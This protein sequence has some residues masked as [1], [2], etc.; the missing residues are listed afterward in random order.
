MTSSPSATRVAGTGTPAVSRR[1]LHLA[2]DRAV[3][4]PL[5]TITAAHGYGKTEVLSS[6]ARTRRAGW[7]RA[8]PAH[9]V[10]AVLGAALAAAVRTAPEPR[11]W[12]ADLDVRAIV[13]RLTTSVDAPATVVIDEADALVAGPAL[14]VIRALASLSGSP[15]RL[16]MGSRVELGVAD[17]WLR[18]RGR[19]LEL[20]A[21][22]LRFDLEDI[23][24]V[25]GTDVA[26]R[27]PSA[28]EAVA[29]A[30]GGWPAGVEAAGR[31]LRGRSGSASTG[32][33]PSLVAGNGPVVAVA[34]STLLAEESP[35]SRR[36][37]AEVALLGASTAGRLAVVRGEPY[38][39]TAERLND[40]V[41][42]GLASPGADGPYRE[43]QR[44]GLLPVLRGAVVSVPTGAEADALAGVAAEVAGALLGARDRV[45]ALHVLTAAG[46]GE[47]IAEVLEAHAAELLAT[48][49]HDV[50]A[51][52]AAAV[53]GTART[54]TVERLHGDALQARGEWDAAL[55]RYLA[56]TGGDGPLTAEVALRI[57]RLHHLRGDLD[58]AI[59]VFAR[60][61]T[62]LDPDPVAIELWSWWATAH[63]LRGE[64]EPAGHRLAVAEDH[65]RRDGGPRGL[66]FVHTVRSLLATGDG[67]ATGYERAHRAAFAAA[68]RA[69]DRDQLARL[70]VNRGSHHLAEGR[71]TEALFEIERAI[72]LTSA[73]T[74][75][76]VRP[77]A[78]C[79]RAEILVRT[80]RLDEAEADAATARAELEALGARTASYA[81]HLLGDVA[82]ERGDLDRAVT[83]YRR[84][85]DVAGDQADHQAVLPATIG[86]VR[87]LAVSDPGRAAALASSLI[88][89]PGAEGSAGVWLAGAWA[90]LA[91]DDRGLAAERA[92]EAARIAGLRADR[93]GDAEAATVSALLAVDPVT[94]LRD[95][96]RRWHR[97]HDPLWAART[98][99]GL[100]R[101]SHDLGERSRAADLE[102]RLA[103]LGCDVRGGEIG[104][105][106]LCAGTA[107]PLRIRALGGLTIE[108]YGVPV[109]AWGAGVTRRVL[110]VLIV[111]AGRGVSR[112]E[113]ARRIWPERRFADV[114]AP[115][116]QAVRALRDALALPGMR[117]GALEGAARS[118]HL[119]I[120]RVELDLHE[121][122]RAVELGQRAER[123]GR[124]R[125]ALLWLRTAQQLHRGALLAGEP[126]DTQ[127]GEPD[128]VSTRRATVE[129]RRDAVDRALVRIGSR[130]DTASRR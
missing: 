119:R 127:A 5:V 49:Q 52:A 96:A 110:A 43:A 21:S 37:L 100:A 65:A 57:G 51:T 53:H 123:S 31:Y 95:A 89:M 34:R 98:E 12:P 26:S 27:W 50:V 74:A 38:A 63:W 90:A 35:G 64:R 121:F 59:A 85:L 83:R 125:E 17:P 130:S 113:L 10:P 18:G 71:Y 44:I 122:E 108:R 9:R 58:E 36:L 41:R 109:E 7:L 22:D 105:R 60:A 114:E 28:V 107:A 55:E 48:G 93:R 24:R 61:R 33:L 77:I 79:N 2:I 62:G 128:G 94:A 115:L 73:A 82:R 1:S 40:L 66:A 80:G 91:G 112:E 6:W 104:H 88:G 25:L 78:R 84:A 20:D 92:G 54:G 42:R 126:W 46:A 4:R 81:L 45:T 75:S 69:G 70:R 86:L 23:A 15:L 68:D 87:T 56:S 3:A 16:V 97:L 120:D 102:L 103:R 11:E 67:D 111:L 101:R 129:A 32:A 8:T 29:T 14:E 99:L 13:E 117:D 72:G 124:F 19:V 106:L 116:E 118:L 76:T 39:L 47:R 30:T